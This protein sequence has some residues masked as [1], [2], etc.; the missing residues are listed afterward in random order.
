MTFEFQVE[1]LDK[2]H[3]RDSFDCGEESLNSFLFRFAR[4][5]DKKRISKTYVAVLPN[6]NRIYGYYTLASGSIKFEIL[7]PENKI[8]KYP[9]P[10]VHLARLAVD[11]STKGQGLG[12]FL[13]I[14]AFKQCLIVSRTLGIYAIEVIA[15]SKKAKSFYLKY[16]FTELMDDKLHL[17][18]S[19]E[20]VE[21]LGLI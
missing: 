20:A 16:G 15:L 9:V 19:M 4:Q 3:N 17:Y 5:N 6:D 14:D 8:P 10:V 18:L 21:K 11:K 7:P 12:E 13:L 1:K 2:K